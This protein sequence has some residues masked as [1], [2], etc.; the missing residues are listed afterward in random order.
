M[1][2]FKQLMGTRLKNRTTTQFA[3]PKLCEGKYRTF[4]C[5]LRTVYQPISIRHR[6]VSAFT[7]Y[8]LLLLAFKGNKN[9]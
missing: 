6:V 9:C 8:V 7:V 1:F 2:D 3:Q 5:Q 4:E